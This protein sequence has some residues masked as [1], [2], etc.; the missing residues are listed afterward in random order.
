MLSYAHSLIQTG[1]LWYM[2]SIVLTEDVMSDNII[3][4]DYSFYK[5][6]FTGI[7]EIDQS[8]SV[9]R[10]F[11]KDN[12][13]DRIFNN[14]NYEC[15]D[16]KAG[17][18]TM[19]VNMDASDVDAG[20][21]YPVV[22]LKDGSER[23]CVYK[24]EVNNRDVGIMLKLSNKALYFNAEQKHH[25]MCS[26]DKDSLFTIRKWKN[27]FTFIK[28]TTVYLSDFSV[29]GLCV[30]YHMNTVPDKEILQAEIWIWSRALKCVY[31]I[32]VSAK[33]VN[34]GHFFVNYTDFINQHNDSYCRL[35]E[36]FLV[37][38][39]EGTYIQSR[40]ELKSN[41]ADDSSN[42]Q[43]T[44][45]DESD[46]YIISEPLENKK[47][48]EWA[49][50]VYFDQ[51]SQLS[52][53]IVERKIMYKSM[54]RGQII[55]Y[56]LKKSVLT[57]NIL[58]RRD[59]FSDRKL[60]LRYKNTDGIERNDE[61]EFAITGNKMV[62]DGVIYTFSIDYNNINWIPLR[63][64]IVIL[65][66]MDDYLYEFRVVG[67]GK[68]FN[69]QIADMY[70]YSF[71]TSDKILVYITETIGMKIAI[72]CRKKTK[73]DS[74]K[75]RANER[76]AH[77]LYGFLKI[78][79]T[80]NNNLLFYEKF[81]TAAQDN[82]YYMF[83]YFMKKKTSGIKPVYI[84]E[85][86]QE[87]YKE[88]KSLYGRHVVSF[89]SI[90]HLLFLQAADL[91]IST[92]SKRHCYRWR[93][94]N[95]KLMQ[96]LIKKKF[97]FLQHGVLG[98]KRVENIYGKQY[99]NR[100]D[101]FIAS[102]DVEK[103]IIKKWFGYLDNEIAVTGL[104][105]WDK[106]NNNPQS[107]PMIFYMPTWRNWVYEVSEEEFVQTDYYKAYQEI[108][109]SPELD[110]ILADNDINMVFCLHPKCRPYL[111][112]LKSRSARIKIFDFDECRINEMLMKCSAFITD[113][114]SASWDVY[115]ME[116]PV[117]FYQFDYEKYT[118]M[119]GSYIN[120][121]KEIFGCRTTDFK[122]FI[123]ELSKCINGGFKDNAHSME[124]IDNYLPLRDSRHRKRIYS[125]IMKMLK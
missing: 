48:F 78:F 117:I 9:E 32:P 80:R 17:V 43:H 12:K 100:A 21:W 53:K 114:S 81:C 124:L 73:Y 25:Y 118:E 115:Y 19:S 24:D 88:L 57:M 94:G 56:S 20:T 1:G 101:L 10:V 99:A 2:A 40:L 79:Y 46:R 82:S 11:L 68:K 121:E 5:G 98:F 15:M 42:I 35:W 8:D 55:D 111:H 119:Q 33:D 38:N 54:F 104:A 92:D 37:C 122:G 105:R 65:G 89:M 62:E 58:F 64:E 13:H 120:F 77:A 70:R 51:L 59:E 22:A 14:V 7:F 27:K 108:I 52:C 85:K 125:A 50:Q 91:F 49:F 109:N 23:C 86:E 67:G 69:N 76:I 72:E 123:N 112:C 29:N 66:K 97:V 34:N 74:F 103:E 107:P 61:Y 95:T 96:I 71:L 18:Y 75:Y 16:V 106:L 47:D 28:K 41:C 113:Y 36:M 30:E 6:I 84:I 102:S 26:L 110:K 39:Q 116:K 60:I 90:R 93:S 45:A 4:N 31:R 44:D 63:Y 83:E 87:V 3:I